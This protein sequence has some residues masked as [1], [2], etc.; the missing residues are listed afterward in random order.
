[1]VT[2]QEGPEFD[3]MP[4]DRL[5]YQVFRNVCFLTDTLLNNALKQSS[6]SSI[7]IVHISIFTSA[8]PHLGESAANNKKH[9]IL[10]PRPLGFLIGRFLTTILYKFLACTI[11]VTGPPANFNLLYRWT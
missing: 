8:D 6:A 10:F 3:S 7:Y 2:F 5:P 4:G 11:R 9:I 1:M